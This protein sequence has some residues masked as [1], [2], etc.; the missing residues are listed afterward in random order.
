MRPPP[1]SRALDDPSRKQPYRRC[2]QRPG[3]FRRQ[4]LAIRKQSK[5]I[6]FFLHISST[7]YR[8]NASTT[9]DTKP[10]GD[11]MFGLA[12][13]HSSRPKLHHAV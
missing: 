5:K 10:S 11:L 6:L 8:S 12:T 2:K 3:Q 4:L 7:F 13:D 1:L 9:A